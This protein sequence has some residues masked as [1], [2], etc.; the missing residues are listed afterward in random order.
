MET[1]YSGTHTPGEEITINNPNSRAIHY[2]IDFGTA[3]AVKLRIAPGG[4]F[5]VVVGTHGPQ[6]NIEDFSSPG[7]REVKRD[8]KGNGVD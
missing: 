6:I 8:V 1:I 5:T 4:S 2:R 7:L 3:G